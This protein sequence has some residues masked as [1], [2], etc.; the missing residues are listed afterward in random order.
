MLVSW[1][2]QVV[3]ADFEDKVW[4]GRGFVAVDGVLKRLNVI[5]DNQINITNPL[6]KSKSA[7][8]WRMICETSLVDPMRKDVPVSEIADNLRLF[9]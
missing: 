4:K 8:D 5:P 9:L 1:D 7:L 2:V 6:L 3:S